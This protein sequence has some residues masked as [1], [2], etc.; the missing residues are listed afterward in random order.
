MPTSQSL[1]PPFSWPRRA[2]AVLVIILIF[3][4]ALVVLGV[5]PLVTIG[6]AVVA[7]VVA[8][9]GEAPSTVPGL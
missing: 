6:A 7:A 3:I 4:T 9:T 5:P 1:V 2:V 8:T